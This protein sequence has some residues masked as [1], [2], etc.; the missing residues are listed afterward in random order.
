M[1]A[2]KLEFFTV[3]V[4][5]NAPILL[6]NNIINKI[7]DFYLQLNLNYLIILLSL[8]YFKISLYPFSWYAIIKKVDFSNKTIS[9]KFK[10]IKFKK[11]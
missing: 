7:M 5:N 3:T 11:N 4:L 2:V 1:K 9:I 6:L 10:K 8:S